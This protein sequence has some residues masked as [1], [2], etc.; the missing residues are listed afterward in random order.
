MARGDSRTQVARHVIVRGLLLV[1]LGMIYNGLLR[2]E[3]PD[4]RLPSVLGRI[5]LAYLFAG[6]IVL[7]TTWRGRLAWIADCW[8]GIGRH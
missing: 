2:F 7:H 6:L 3:W 5:G 8:W 1:L 4:T